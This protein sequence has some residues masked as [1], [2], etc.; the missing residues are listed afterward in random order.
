MAASSRWYMFPQ[1]ITVGSTVLEF[2]HP[3]VIDTLYLSGK[4]TKLFWPQGENQVGVP[5]S[6]ETYTILEK[7]SVPVALSPDNISKNRVT[8]SYEVPNVV[9]ER[10]AEGKPLQTAGGETESLTQIEGSRAKIGDA[11]YFL[12]AYAANPADFDLGLIVDTETMRAER[13]GINVNDDD[14]LHDMYPALYWAKTYL[15]LR[16]YQTPKQVNV[17]PASTD[18]GSPAYKQWFEGS[19]DNFQPKQYYINL[20]DKRAK[21]ASEVPANF[22][23]LFEDNQAA[24]RKLAGVL[25]LAE[26]YVKDAHMEKVQLQIAERCYNFGVKIGLR[27]V[28]ATY[29]RI[30][31]NPDI[32]S[33]SDYLLRNPRFLS[34]DNAGHLSALAFLLMVARGTAVDFHGFKETGSI[35]RAFETVLTNREGAPDRVS[36]YNEI[37]GNIR[38]SRYTMQGITDRQG[39]GLTWVKNR[40]TN[41]ANTMTWEPN[42]FAPTP[43][44]DQP[45][46]WFSGAYVDANQWMLTANSLFNYGDHPAD[47]S[48]TVGSDVVEFDDE[49]FDIDEIWD[50]F[51]IGRKQEA[52]LSSI[53]HLS[54]NANYTVRTIVEYALAQGLESTKDYLQER[55]VSTIKAYDKDASRISEDKDFFVY[56]AMFS[57]F[58]TP[59]AINKTLLRSYTKSP[60]YSYSVDSVKFKTGREFVEW[61]DSAEAQGTAHSMGWTEASRSNNVVVDAY[62]QLFKATNSNILGLPMDA[63][64]SARTEIVGDKLDNYFKQLVGTVL[65]SEGLPNYSKADALIDHDQFTFLTGADHHFIHSGTHGDR[66]GSAEQYVAVTPSNEANGIHIP[67]LRMCDNKVLLAN[68]AK[69]CQQVFN[70]QVVP[71]LIPRSIIEDIDKHSKHLGLLKTIPMRNVLF[72]DGDAMHTNTCVL[73]QPYGGQTVA[74]IVINS[75]QLV[76]LFGGY[77][78]NALLQALTHEIAHYYEKS[79]IKN[80]DRLRFEKLLGHKQLYPTGKWAGEASANKSEQFAVLAEY[81]VWGQSARNLYYT[82]GVEEVLKYFANQY[83]TE[84]MLA[85]KR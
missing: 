52:M 84:E 20:I 83:M 85:Y 26:S 1:P 14:A 33:Y 28:A 51:L 79:Y 66:G 74:I 50:K 32:D 80:A 61:L 18:K 4:P 24:I 2:Q 53:V 17:I 3:F 27:S 81:M 40:F 57:F 45:E 42:L 47:G 48:Y 13:V 39:Q 75:K 29:L 37:I 60:F 19:V 9:H 31:A 71:K 63:P 62:M 67:F 82:N 77:N 72:L 55:M 35:D 23:I 36:T 58:L 44:P 56:A 43:S 41:A 65:D 5:I 49:K 70:N 6:D 76:Q 15:A 73:S 68:L 8:P 16:A 34:A 25:E 78:T 59:K 38:E 30:V 46:L 12:R 69:I 11:K 21:E 22:R 54:R 10:N 64:S 7:R